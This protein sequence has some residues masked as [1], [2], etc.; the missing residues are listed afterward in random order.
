MRS[1]ESGATRDDCDDKYDWEGFLSPV[2]EESFAA[3]MHHHRKQADGNLRDSDNWQ[4]GIPKNQYMKSMWRHFIDVWFLHRGHRRFDVHG[5]GHELTMEECL[6]AL[7][8]NVSGYQHEN[9]TERDTIVGIDE[10]AGPDTTAVCLSC[11]SILERIEPC[12]PAEC[13]VTRTIISCDT[14]GRDARPTC[15]SACYHGDAW[16]PKGDTR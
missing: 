16:V 2:V 14:C 4:K 11:G 13:G 6:N 1:F 5:D 3:Y 15:A 10:A 9:L 12:I 7:R 8:F